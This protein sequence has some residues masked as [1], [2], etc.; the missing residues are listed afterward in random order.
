[1]TELKKSGGSTKKFLVYSILLSLVL[2][3]AFVF[4][5][6]KYWQ[7]SGE[8]ET[9]KTEYA[10]T[11]RSFHKAEIQGLLTQAI[12]ELQRGEFDL[13]LKDTS[14]FFTKLSEEVDKSDEG[15]YLIEER[16]ELK[17]IFDKRDSTI[18]MLAQRDPKSIETL[19]NLYLFYQKTM[20]QERQSSGSGN[21]AN[22]SVENSNS[23][24]QESANSN[25]AN[26]SPANHNTANTA[27]Q[28][29]AEGNDQSLNN[30]NT[31]NSNVNIQNTANGNVSANSQKF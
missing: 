2:L 11:Q 6:W 3:V 23:A 30:Q 17:N 22:Q 18:T 31:T 26:Q 20:G 5:A 25:V 4:T 12:V 8:L 21:A 13:A 14:G 16:G 24:N 15:A 28:N 1:M 9:T 27:N 19:T 10:K 29:V 7:S